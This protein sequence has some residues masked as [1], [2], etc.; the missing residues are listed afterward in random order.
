MGFD[1]EKLEKNLLEAVEEYAASQ[2]A[3]KDDMYIMSIEYF[4]EFTTFIAIRANTYSYLKEQ[5]DEGDEDYTYYKYCEE[6]WDL[7]EDVKDVSSA[8]QAEYNKM[9]ETYDDALEEAQ[10][11]H[12]GKIIDICIK[13][14]H[15]FKET[16][17]YRKFPKLYLNVYLREYFDEEETLRIF[18]ELN[19]EDCIEEYAS[20]L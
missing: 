18:A 13:V 15:Q 9:E 1:Y 2:L 12:V 8:L 14:M 17:T 10:E 11:Q 19:G 5:A 7:Y 3:Q 6:E 20:W 16:D 4:P